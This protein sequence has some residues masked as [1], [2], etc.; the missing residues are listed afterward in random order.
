MNIRDLRSGEKFDTG[1]CTFEAL[2]QVFAG[3]FFFVRLQFDDV[4]QLLLTADLF[5]IGDQRRLTEQEHMGTTFRRTRRQRQQCFQGGLVEL[6]G[7]IHQQIDFLAGQAQLHHLLKDRIRLR[8]GDVQRLRHLA[9]HAGRITGATGRDHD[10]LHRLLV[11]AGD[12]RLAQ[13]RLAAA[14]RP[15]DH[16]QQLTVA[17]EVV[18][19][20]QYRLALGREEFETRHPWSERVVAQVIMAEERLVGMQTSHRDL[21]NL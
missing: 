17:R 20:P 14:Q 19:L 4:E 16:Q 18:Q 5:Q 3:L 21:I 13:Q 11:G 9:Q 1:P 12:Q 15:R 10:A 7:V 8:V 2:S 6:L